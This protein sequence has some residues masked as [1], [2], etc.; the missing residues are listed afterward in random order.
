[1]SKTRTNR[2]GQPIKNQ[3]IYKAVHSKEEIFDEKAI[4]IPGDK[5]H[6]EK[7]LVQNEWERN[8]K[9]FDKLER[10]GLKIWQKEKTTIPNMKGAIAAIKNIPRHKTAKDKQGQQKAPT[11]EEGQQTKGKINIFDAPDQVKLIGSL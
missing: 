1:M 4:T 11:D 2:D 10:E 7:L 5:I 8:K 9:Y 6:S 3:Y